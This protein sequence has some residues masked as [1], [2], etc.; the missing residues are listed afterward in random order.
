MSVAHRL[1][2]LTVAQLRQLARERGL[3]GYSKLK[4]AELVDVLERTGSAEPSPDE[5]P[6]LPG[7]SPSH[8][9][10]TTVDGDHNGDRGARFDDEIRAWD[11]DRGAVPRVPAEF[12]LQD[13]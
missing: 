9:G 12:E 10:Q 1:D 3:K 11:E 13:R 4:K 8:T 5:Q 7:T 6:A 2:D